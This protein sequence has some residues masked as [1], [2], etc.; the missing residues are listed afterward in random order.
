MPT[1]VS[2]PLFPLLNPIKVMKKT[3]LHF[4]LILLTVSGVYAQVPQAFKYQGIARNASGN[5]LASTVLTIRPNIHDGTATGAIVYQE[6]QSVAT[7]AFGLFNIEIGRGTPVIGSIAG[8]NWG[9]GDKYMEVE[10]DFGSGYVSMGT[11]QLLSV[12][13]ALYAA[14]GPT[15]PTGATGVTGTNGTNGTN[16]SAGSTGVTGSAGINGTNGSTGATG[17]TGSTGATGATGSAGINGTNGSTGATGVTGSTGATG[18]TGSAGING[19]NGSIGA[20]GV[21]GSTGATGVTGSAG[22]NGTNGSTGA[23]GVTG[24][25][26]ATGVTGSA[27]INGTNGSTGATGVNGSTGATGAT[28]VTGSVGNTGSNGATGTAGATGAT[29]STG[30]VGA[31]SILGIAEYIQTIQGSNASVPPGNAFSINTELINTIPSAIVSSTGNSG[32]VFTF[33]AIG[34]Y[35]LDYE[36][37]LA[38]A[39]SI[40]LYTGPFAGALAIDNNSIAGSSTATTWLHGKRFVVVSVAPLVVQLSSAVG[41]CSVGTAGTAAGFYIVR[42]HIVKVL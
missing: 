7:N 12:P 11:S 42:L 37:S 21:T 29:G 3:L 40:A 17:V 4:A 22:I 34:T 2:K 41:T 20:T 31:A 1:P 39:G 33:N 14:N 30:A 23:T 13:Y 38:T 24:S 8:V 28:G 16:G 27:G 15:G 5:P 26:G 36:T 35:E 18:V 10:I 9:S 19:T 6:T 25:T 32:T